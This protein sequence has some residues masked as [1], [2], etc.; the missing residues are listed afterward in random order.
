MCSRG[1]NV[2]AKIAAAISANGPDLRQLATVASFA[3]SFTS[4]KAETRECVVSVTAST[5]LRLRGASGVPAGASSAR[6]PAGSGT[7]NDKVSTLLSRDGGG[8]AIR[9][10]SA[11]DEALGAN[12]SRS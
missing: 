5:V 7:S 8:V 1:N 12:A 2:T 6:V 11:C 4:E 9:R 3:E 10:A